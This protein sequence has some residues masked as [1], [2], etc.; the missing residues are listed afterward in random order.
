MKNSLSLVW[1]EQVCAGVDE[2]APPAARGCYHPPHVCLSPFYYR[3]AWDLCARIHRL[4]IRLGMSAYVYT[5]GSY[6]SAGNIWIRGLDED[7]PPA[8]RGRHHPPHV[9]PSPLFG[10]V[11]TDLSYTDMFTPIGHIRVGVTY[12]YVYTEWSYTSEPMFLPRGVDEDAPPAARGRHHPP[13]V[14]PPL[15]FGWSYTSAGG[16]IR[17]RVMRMP[18]PASRLPLSRVSLPLSVGRMRTYTPT[19]HIGLGRMHTYIPTGHTRVRETYGYVASM[20]TLLPLLVRP[21]PLFHYRLA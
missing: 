12:G 6:T 19:D 8:P 2:D 5:D 7:A 3:L 20:K 15:V 10:Y 16:H 9:P 14:R 11:Y 4:I 21:P 13:H 1:G 17:V 18:P